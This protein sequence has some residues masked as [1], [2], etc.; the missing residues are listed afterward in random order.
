MVKGKNLN[1]FFPYTKPVL[2]MSPTIGDPFSVMCM[3]PLSY[4]EYMYVVHYE[5]IFVTSSVVWAH[6]PDLAPEAHSLDSCRIHRISI[7]H[8]RVNIPIFSFSKLS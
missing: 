5:F 2:Q 6:F 1:Y 4:E 3:P 7:V 8:G